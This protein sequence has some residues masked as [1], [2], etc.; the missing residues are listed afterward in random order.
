GFADAADYYARSSSK[1]VLSD[2]RIPTLIV[3]AADDPFL[4]EACYPV[5]EACDHPHVYLETPA[6]GGHVGFVAFNADK[7]FWSEQR[8]VEFLEEAC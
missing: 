2:I 7:M 3:N 5:A 6:Q 4:P 8:A 1:P